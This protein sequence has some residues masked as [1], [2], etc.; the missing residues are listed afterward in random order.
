MPRYRGN[1]NIFLASLTLVTGCAADE[2]G[3]ADRNEGAESLMSQ[4]RDEVSMVDWDEGLTQEEQVAEIELVVSVM[5]KHFG[6]GVVR[7]GDDEWDLER[8]LNWPG[9]PYPSHRAPD[10]YF[11]RVNFDFSDIE[12][13]Q[14]TQEKALAALDDIGLSP[15]GDLPQ[16]YDAERRNQ[17]YVVGGGDDH[18]RLFLIQQRRDGAE[19]SAQFRTRH[20]DHESMYEAYE[21]NWED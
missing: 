10:H 3:T 16:T 18:G 11:Y 2:P 4:E 9:I 15:D 1:Y 5:K 19:I 8:Y 21:A 20:S 12:A 6:E 7:L 13:N 14:E 17:V